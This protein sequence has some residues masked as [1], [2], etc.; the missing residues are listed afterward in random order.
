MKLKSIIFLFYWLLCCSFVNVYGVNF[1]GYFKSKKEQVP[2]LTQA[3]AAEGQGNWE[4]VLRLTNNAIALN[5]DEKD[6]PVA[7]KQEA[8]ARLGRLF[9]LKDRAQSHLSGGSVPIAGAP[10]AAA[11]A[12]AAARPTEPSPIP[13][14]VPWG[15]GRGGPKFS[16]IYG[17]AKM[18]AEIARDAESLR[19][20]VQEIQ[21]CMDNIPSGAKEEVREDLEGM[22]QSALS[23]LDES[24]T[25]TKP[26]ADAKADGEAEFMRQGAAGTSASSSSSSSSGPSTSSA[27]SSSAPKATEEAGPGI[28]R[29][30]M[31]FNCLFGFDQDRCFIRLQKDPEKFKPNDYRR[32]RKILPLPFPFYYGEGMR[33]SSPVTWILT[34]QI[35]SSG[36]N[37]PKA[38]IDTLCG[39]AIGLEDVPVYVC[40]SFWPEEKPYSPESHLC[41]DNHCWAIRNMVPPTE[42]S[43]NVSS[44]VFD[45]EGIVAD[46]GSPIGING[47]GRSE[48]QIFHDSEYV[49]GDIARFRLVDNG[50][51]YSS[52]WFLSIL[53]NHPEYPVPE[54]AVIVYQIIV[55]KA[56]SKCDPREGDAFASFVEKIE[57]ARQYKSL[58]PVELILGSKFGY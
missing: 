14:D 35:E 56:R 43:H 23:R 57:S 3:E 49:S 46:E 17:E 40:V 10:A 19:R 52:G 4:E 28:W 32:G 5:L 11:A 37:I 24:G 2:L 1:A 7:F 30:L 50:K 38:L 33:D 55:K 51:C 39:R 25:E 48:N 18:H 15:P 47:L 13:T 9:E 29:D 34:A 20:L 16:K 45:P 22:L 54:R 44:G 41:Y 58:G 26:K 31:V 8:A 12:A 36:A 42:T 21:D 27:A 6:I 53:D